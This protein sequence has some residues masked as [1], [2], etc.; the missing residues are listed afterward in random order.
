MSLKLSIV[1][2]CNN[3]SNQQNKSL[4]SIEC[5][6]WAFTVSQHNVGEDSKI[7]VGRRRSI[8]FQDVF[9]LDIS[10][11]FDAISKLQVGFK[12]FFFSSFRKLFSKL[13]LGPIRR[14]SGERCLSCKPGNQGLTSSSHV[15]M[16]GG[17]PLYKTVHQ[18]PHTSKTVLIQ[19]WTCLTSINVLGLKHLE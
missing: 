4:K 1:C 16:E 7:L 15:K 10:N 11:I 5:H 8:S 14:I 9:H 6:S 3:Q 12:S 17:N 13:A 18:P 19:F 2:L